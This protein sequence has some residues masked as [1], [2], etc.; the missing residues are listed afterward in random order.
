MGKALALRDDYDAVRLRVLAR[1]TKHAAQSR[2]LLALAAIYHGASRG[3]AARLA[4]TDRQIVRDWVVRFN[5]EGPDGMRDR[6]GG[7]VAP[8]L[9]P[10]MLEALA[11][12]I[13]QEPIPSMHGVVRWRL[14]DLCMWLH[15]EFDVDLS[16]SRLSE[17]V[18]RHDFRFLTARPR[19]HAQDPEAQE[20][21]KKGLPAAIATIQALHPEAAIEL[22]WA[23]EA[24]V[25]QKNKLT[26]RWA[27]RGTRPRASTDQRTSSAYLFGAI[28]PALG[29]GAGLVLPWCNIEA[30]NHHLSAIAQAVAPNAHAVLL[31]DQAGWHTSLRLKVP[32]N[33]TIMPIP[34]RSPELNPVENLWQFIRNTWLSNRVFRSYN[35]IVDL[36]CDAWSRL[37]A[38][39]LRIMSIGLRD[40]AHGF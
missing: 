27:R 6:H 4:G 15:E 38:Q 12:R 26:R 8:R 40:W 19:H 14:C 25:G 39:P 23:D 20:L 1:T 2:R 17:I 10:A 28:C 3:D 29:K 36:C 37:L 35:Q 33:I 32:P 11:A 30:M 34:P 22:W 21:F 7:G 9:T 16:V 18:R 24:R 13:E 5:A 31:L